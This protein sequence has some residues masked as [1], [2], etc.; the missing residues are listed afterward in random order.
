MS[1]SPR[2]LSSDEE[3]FLSGVDGLWDEVRLLVDVEYAVDL[4]D[5]P[6]GEAEVSVGG[7]DDCG[8]GCGVRES[9]VVWVGFREALRDDGGEFVAAQCRYSWAKP[10]RL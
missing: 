1:C 10:M 7:A 2:R 8:D 3:C 5:E 9:G 4:G 6:V